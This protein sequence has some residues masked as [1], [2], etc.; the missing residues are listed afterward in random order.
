MFMKHIDVI[1]A[2]HSWKWTRISLATGFFKDS[3]S[4][5][6]TIYKIEIVVGKDTYKD[7]ENQ[8]KD[9]KVVGR[10]SESLRC[11]VF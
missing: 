4:K 2:F 3:V 10:I 5:N 8:T 11:A 9:I 6:R 7:I 1:S